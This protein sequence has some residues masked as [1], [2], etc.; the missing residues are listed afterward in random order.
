MSNR[1]G[2]RALARRALRRSLYPLSPSRWNENSRTSART[3]LPRCGASASSTNYEPD[4]LVDRSK[5]MTSGPRAVAVGLVL[6][7]PDLGERAGSFRS[8]AMSSYRQG[9]PTAMFAKSGY[10][11]TC[12]TGFRIWCWASRRLEWQRSSFC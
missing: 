6:H 9:S 10:R 8:A 7:P 2:C 11:V 12:R 4:F 1:S 3:T 5:G